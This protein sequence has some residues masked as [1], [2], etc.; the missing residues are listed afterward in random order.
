MRCVAITARYRKY[1]I[2][3]F[4]TV[5]NFKY[6]HQY[7]LLFRWVDSAL[8]SRYFSREGHRTKKSTSR[9][10]HFRVSHGRDFASTSN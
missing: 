1:K 4:D 8:V 3:F 2:A 9:C 6:Q 7:E 10:T 5:I